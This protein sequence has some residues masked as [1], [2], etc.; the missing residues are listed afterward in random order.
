MRVLCTVND[1]LRT[2]LIHR[3]APLE[4]LSDVLATATYLI[5]CHPCQAT[6][7]MMPYVLLFGTTPSYNE[8]H[9]FSCHRFHNTIATTSHKLAA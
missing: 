3:A 7:S 5:N 4:F 8:L 9:V 6:G 1:C 2:M